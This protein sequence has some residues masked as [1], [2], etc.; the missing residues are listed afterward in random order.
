MVNAYILFITF[1][2]FAAL[3]GAALVVDNAAAVVEARDVEARAL[4]AVLVFGAFTVV[5]ARIRIT[6]SLV[7]ELVVSAFAVVV[8]NPGIVFEAWAG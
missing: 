1:T 8:A 2:V 3:V 6:S 4:F 7:T 5:A